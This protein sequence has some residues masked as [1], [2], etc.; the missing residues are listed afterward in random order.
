M[1]CGTGKAPKPNPLPP[2]APTMKLAGCREDKPQ[3]GKSPLLPVLAA[4]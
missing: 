1:A 2:A 4:T 3:S